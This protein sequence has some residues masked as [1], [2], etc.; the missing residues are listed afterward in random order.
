VTVLPAGTDVPAPGSERITVPLGTLGCGWV[1][2]AT[3]SPSAL[4]LWVAASLDDPDTLGMATEG[5]VVVA[6]GPVE[7]TTVIEL[8]GRT[9]DSAAGSVR[10]T[11]P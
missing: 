1:T 2:A 6:D 4:N 7:T 9:L 11:R 8:C 3:E 5:D 10:M